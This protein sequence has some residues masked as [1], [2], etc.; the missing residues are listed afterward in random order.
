MLSY[1]ETILGN[2]HILLLA[3]LGGTIPAVLW[4]LF[5]LREDRED[6]EPLR[7]LVLTF[8]A[9]MLAVILVL[10]IEKYI[11][12]LKFGNTALIFLWAASEEII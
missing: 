8:I 12:G 9:G 5:W 11:S 2:P 1:F 4:L 10:P 6:P 3:F 7:F